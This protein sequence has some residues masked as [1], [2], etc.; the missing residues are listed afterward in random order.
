MLNNFA[1]LNKWMEI[2]CQFTGNIPNM[3]PTGAMVHINGN[4]ISVLF[5]F[6]L[7][8]QFYFHLTLFSV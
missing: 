3:K 1:I 8:S 6:W 7:R 5:I 2:L 4:S